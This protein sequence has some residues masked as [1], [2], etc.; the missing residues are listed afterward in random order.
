[1]S[2]NLIVIYSLL[3]MVAGL[4]GVVCYLAIVNNGERREL[5]HLLVYFKRGRFDETELEAKKIEAD[6][7]VKIAQAGF[8]PLQEKPIELTDND[9]MD[10]ARNWKNPRDEGDEYEPR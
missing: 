6:K 2:T 8:P 4:G 7:K 9:G 10:A 5:L 1:M 3:A